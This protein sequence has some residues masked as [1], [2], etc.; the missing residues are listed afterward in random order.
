MIATLI[1]G[2]D[3]P[4]RFHETGSAPIPARWTRKKRT[5]VVWASP[6]RDRSG[7]AGSARSALLKLDGTHGRFAGGLGSCSQGCCEKNSGCWSHRSERAD[8]S[9]WEGGRAAG[10]SGG[11]GRGDG[12]KR[13]G[14]VRAKERRRNS[15]T[16]LGGAETTSLKERAELATLE[17][18]HWSNAGRWLSGK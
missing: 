2:T 8:G 15:G 12:K 5:W 16:E 3:P 1:R 18:R 13:R 6:S 7:E 11:D 14:V 17:A 10:G 4:L 9:R